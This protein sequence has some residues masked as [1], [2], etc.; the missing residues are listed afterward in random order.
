MTL[1][2]EESALMAIYDSP[3]SKELQVVVN[4]MKECPTLTEVEVATYLRFLLDASVEKAREHA[5]LLI[6]LY[7][8]EACGPGGVATE[9]IRS[10]TF[11]PVTC[12]A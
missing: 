7:K 4:V 5:A 8:N 6:T 11:R 9:L 1:V 12:D 3:K 10:Y 2:Q